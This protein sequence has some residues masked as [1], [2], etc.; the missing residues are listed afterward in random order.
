M[1]Q[2]AN[3]ALQDIFLMQVFHNYVFLNAQVVNIGME[4]LVLIA[5]MG[6]YLAQMLV[7]VSHVDQDFILI[8]IL[9]NVFRFVLKDNIM[10]D[11]FNY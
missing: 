5:C 1:L 8:L 11:Y 2:A 6:A 3:H 7:F 4:L 10:Y 9:L